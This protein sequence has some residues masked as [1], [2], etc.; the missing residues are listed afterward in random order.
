MLGSFDSNHFC[1]PRRYHEG[2]PERLYQL[3]YR[4]ASTNFIQ[5]AHYSQQTKPSL[6]T[7]QQSC[8]QPSSSSKLIAAKTV[9]SSHTLNFQLSI[10]WTDSSVA[11]TFTIKTL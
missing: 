8:E 5:P 10:C 7:H 6:Q 4:F 3:L 2:W 1:C 11:Q 9:M